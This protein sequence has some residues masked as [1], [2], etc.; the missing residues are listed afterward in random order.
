MAEDG[1]RAARE[2]FS[3]DAMLAGVE[4][5]IAEAVDQRVPP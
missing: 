1:R 3:L 5:S 2:R 4:R